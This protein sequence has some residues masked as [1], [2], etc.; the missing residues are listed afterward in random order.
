MWDFVFLCVLLLV[1]LV[2]VTRRGAERVAGLFVP[3][4]FM[5]AGFTGGVVLEAMPFSQIRS[6]FSARTLIAGL[7][8]LFG[9]R[10]VARGVRGWGRGYRSEDRGDTMERARLVHPLIALGLLFSGAFVL[11]EAA[12]ARH[13]ALEVEG[14]LRDSDTGVLRGADERWTPAPDG[15]R[16]AVLLV[17]GVLGS[18]ADF[19]SLPHELRRRG[20]G[21]REMRLP[22]HGTTP[23]ELAETTSREWRS[24]VMAAYDELAADHDHVSIVGF[25]LG[26]ML[27]TMTASDRPVHRLVLVNPYAGVTATP[28]WSPVATDTMIDF[29]SPLSSYVMRARHFMKVNKRDGADRLIAYRTVPLSVSNELRGLKFEF[30]DEAAL[31]RIKSPTLLL[32]SENDNTAPSSAGRELYGVLEMSLPAAAFSMHTYTESDHF[33]FLDFDEEDA[34]RRTADWITSSE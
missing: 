7:I 5:V 32:L 25:S 29:M 6:G 33:M 13:L 2:V 19:G 17:H 10:L 9:M 1:L 11:H 34:V 16:Q 12:A 21:V 30:D 28:S 31:S 20:F 8:G 27:A 23:R 26:G 3:T 15:G 18:R 14:A 22:G 4:L 24:A